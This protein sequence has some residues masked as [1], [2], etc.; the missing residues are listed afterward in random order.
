M[1]FAWPAGLLPDGLWC[2]A[3]RLNQ[4]NLVNKKKTSPL[5]R[6]GFYCA[7][8]PYI[9]SCCL[10]ATVFG[11]VE[12]DSRTTFQNVVEFL[13]LLAGPGAAVVLG[14]L[15]LRQIKRNPILG[16]KGFAY[17]ALVLG[18]LGLLFWV[19]S[20]VSSPNEHGRQGPPTT[21]T[22]AATTPRGIG[23]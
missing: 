19:I 21:S 10:M 22:Q 2:S 5:A 3:R 18:G 4:G 15:A 11:I 7:I 23:G 12:P 17:T 8:V 9:V 13:V 1:R 14:V 20:L 16:G 6:L